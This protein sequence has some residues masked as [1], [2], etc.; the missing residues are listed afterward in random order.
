[1]IKIKDIPVKLQ[2]AYCERNYSHGGECKNPKYLENGCLV[3][4]PDP[5]GCIRTSDMSISIPLYFDF[6]PLNTWCDYW[7]MKGVD[8]EI[9]VTKIH[10]IKW[11]A[12][13]GLLILRVTCDYYINEFHD[14]YIET[15]NKPN[16]KVV[17]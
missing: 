5:K 7:T 16:L 17:K 2:C 8:T 10:G 11:D 3:F 12:K 13:K 15:A 4:K 6:P 1:M 14:D 9:S